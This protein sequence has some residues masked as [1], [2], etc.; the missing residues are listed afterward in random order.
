[1]ANYNEVTPKQWGKKQKP[2]QTPKKREP[3]PSQETQG[4]AWP[5]SLQNFVDKSFQLAESLPPDQKTLFN[6]QMQTLMAQAIAQNVIWT[7][8]WEVQSLP[9]FSG[10]SA[11]ELALNRPSSAPKRMEMTGDFD[12]SERKRQR[13]SRFNDS[14]RMRLESPAPGSTKEIVGTL[15]ALEKRYLRLTSEPDPAMVRPEKVLVKAFKYVVDKYRGEKLQY[16]YINDQLKAIR[17]DLTVQHISND[18]PMRVY[19]THGRIA[20]ENNDLGEFNQCQLQLTYLYALQK[21][22]AF[23]KH[24]YEFTCYRILYLLLTGNYSDINSIRLELLKSDNTSEHLS[25]EYQTYRD[26]VYK[27][28]ELLT[29]V[30]QGHYHGYFETYKWFLRQ[31]ELKCAAHLLRQFMAT[32]H[33]LLALNTM[34]KAFKKLPLPYLQSEL[35]FS[36]AE[37]MSTLLADFGLSQFADGDFDLAAARGVLQ[38]IVDKGTFK[39]VDIKGQ[40]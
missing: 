20:I 17:Q 15:N 16:L 22:P 14:H 35:G 25:A 38:S 30:V 12:S 40:V 37:T 23:Y 28:L 1:M 34:C 29:F 32:K 21:D 3:A 10:G 36:E 13:M 33:R 5:A 19:E 27:A 24:T 4:A 8:P 31:A 39:K 6:D 11:V 2:K 7:N 26:G 9:V 18:L